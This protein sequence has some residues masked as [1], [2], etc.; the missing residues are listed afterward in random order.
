[1]AFRRKRVGDVFA[2]PTRG[3]S[4]LNHREGSLESRLVEKEKGGNFFIVGCSARR[5]KVLNLGE[6]EGRIQEQGGRARLDRQ[7][8][9]GPIPRLLLHT[10]K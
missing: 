8:L 1:M 4:T 7:R 5:V 10:R 6:T 2:T 3:R 9:N